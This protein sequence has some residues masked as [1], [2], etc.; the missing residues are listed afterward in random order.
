M[1]NEP[2][3]TLDVDWAP[4]FV[5][6][7][8]AN[9]LTKKKIKATWFVTHDTPIWKKLEKNNLFELGWHPNFSE[10]SSQG[11]N[12]DSV[13]T[14]LKNII[15]NAKSIRTHSLVQSTHLLL[16]FHEYGIKNDVSLHLEKSP[17]LIPHHSKFLNLH[18]FPF[19]WGDG[20]EMI[21]S[22]SNWS[23]NNPHYR[24]NGLKI[25]Y[26]HPIHIFL[27]SKNW[28]NY[29]HL[30]SDFNLSE[31]TYENSQNYVNLDQGTGTLFDEITTFLENKQ[32]FTI[33]DLNKIYF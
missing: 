22:K 6:E 7:H 19:F 28:I 13:L 26:F 25:F 5:L 21:E 20:N 3:I 24:V 11:K 15:P 18:R 1:I 30:K 17:N 8:V 29:N 32:S 31:L 12:P 16:K 4:D 9:I 33:E 2:V 27:N 10:N 14:Y 23:M